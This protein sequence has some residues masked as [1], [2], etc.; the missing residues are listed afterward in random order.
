MAPILG[1]TQNPPTS[2]FSRGC[3]REPLL[4][5]FFPARRS[6]S[7]SGTRTAHLPPAARFSS[8]TRGDRPP[9]LSLPPLAPRLPPS[10]PAPPR[11]NPRSCRPQFVGLRVLPAFTTWLLPQAPPASKTANLLPLH[12]ICSSTDRFRTHSHPSSASS[13]EPRFVPRPVRL[14]GGWC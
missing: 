11:P 6:S 1:G 2:P 13:L 14:A 8:R 4:D 3:T 10:S 7:S 12:P 5:G 9:P